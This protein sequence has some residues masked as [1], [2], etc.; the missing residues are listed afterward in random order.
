[1]PPAGIQPDP[2]HAAQRLVRDPDTGKGSVPGRDAR[3]GPAPGGVDRGGD[4]AQ[5][6]LPAAGNLLQ[7]A[8]RGGYRGGPAEQVLVITHHAEAPHHPPPLPDPPPP[9]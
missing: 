7:R 5:C 4:L 2:G 6:P 9:A 3:P 1:G 8:P